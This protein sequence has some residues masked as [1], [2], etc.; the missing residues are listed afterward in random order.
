MVDLI[1]FYVL[2]AYKL[3][4]IYSIYHYLSVLYYH[5]VSLLPYR[6]NF[7]A[8][9]ELNS[10]GEE[11]R[12]RCKIY[13]VDYVALMK[14]GVRTANTSWPSRDCQAWE[15]NLTTTGNYHSIVSE[16]EGLSSPGS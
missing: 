13:D 5:N 8:V 15:Y 4:S 14:A 3:L 6:R 2:F 10:R 12:S 1:F 9:I 11:K 7:S 16:V